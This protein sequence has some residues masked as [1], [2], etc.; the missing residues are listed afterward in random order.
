[1]TENRTSHKGVI[2]RFEGDFAVLYVGPDGEEKCDF[3]KALLPKGS[4]EGD[5]VE[6]KVKAR[7]N[8]TADAKK[9]VRGMID[10]LISR[11]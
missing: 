4:K 10:D 9:K 2:D 3:P 1:M 6:I 8:K 7:K 5:I 11:S